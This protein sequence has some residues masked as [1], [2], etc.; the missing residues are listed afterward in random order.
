MHFE[1]GIWFLVDGDVLGVRLFVRFRWLWVEEG[2][3]L[4]SRSGDLFESKEG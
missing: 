1:C 3:M 4:L 2:I